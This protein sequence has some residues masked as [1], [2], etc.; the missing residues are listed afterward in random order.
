M[1]DRVRC[2]DPERALAV[3]VTLMAVGAFFSSALV[4]VTF[5]LAV[6]LTLPRLARGELSLG[7][8]DLAMMAFGYA[9]LVSGL[10]GICPPY[11]FLY[12]SELKRLLIPYLV[13]PAIT[14][15]RRFLMFM[16]VTGLAGTVVGLRA[17]QEWYFLGSLQ[18]RAFSSTS[19]DMAV[20]LLM[21]IG[22]LVGVVAFSSLPLWKRVLLVI[23]TLIMFGGFMLAQN[24]SV[25]LGLLAGLVVAGVVVSLKRFMICVL[26]IAILIPNLPDLMIRRY[27]N[28]SL[29]DWQSTSTTY[30]MKVY[31]LALEMFRDHAPFGIGR[32]NF[33]LAH[34]YYKEPGDE[35]KPNAHSNVLNILVEMGIP[36]VVAYLWMLIAVGVHL[37]RRIRWELAPGSL[38]SGLVTGI[39][40]SFIG[41]HVAGSFIYNWGYSLPVTLMWAMVGVTY[42][43]RPPPDEKSASDASECS[44]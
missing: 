34:E 39:L 26:A 13:L 36:G 33:I 7:S 29:M 6:L 28:R 1:A 37:L 40:I 16:A 5:L 30:R 17:I 8:L 42:S 31:P 24:R 27:Q 41:F 4:N 3:I 14:T 10:A 2:W 43:H 18:P 22:P 44:A 32:R 23:P 15:R 20:L 11:T 35:I 9:F 38:E 12:T 21:T 19:T 25:L